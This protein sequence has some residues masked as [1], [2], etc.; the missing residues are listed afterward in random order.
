MSAVHLSGFRQEYAR[1]R[2]GNDIRPATQSAS[3]GTT[4]AG[5]QQDSINEAKTL[6]LLELKQSK[7]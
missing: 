6:N 4:V 1:A 5:I 7:L 3:R 2:N